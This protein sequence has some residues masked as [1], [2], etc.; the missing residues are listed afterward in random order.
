MARPNV[1]KGQHA[2]VGGGQRATRPGGVHLPYRFPGLGLPPPGSFDPGLEAQIRASQRGLIDL[3]E[4]T[5]RESKRTGQDVRQGQRKLG[6]EER[7]SV[8]DI[9]RERG[10]A[11]EDAA[12]AQGQLHT[13]F[14]RDIES[15]AIA[16]QRGEEDYQR[17]LVDMQHRYATTAAVQGERSLQQ[18]TAEGGTT[19]A[20]D[21]VRTANQAFDRGNV[22]TGHARSLFDLARSEDQ[23]RRDYGTQRGHIQTELERQLG[24]YDT[25]GTRL[26]QD[27]LTA[28][29]QLSLAALRAAQDRAT[30]LSHAKREQTFYQTDVTGQAYFQAHQNNPNILFPTPAAAGG[31][32]GAHPSAGGTFAP[33]VGHPVYHIG[34]GT[35]RAVSYPRRTARR[36][37]TRY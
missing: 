9:G 5:H 30:K 31:T 17:T 28:R 27:T 12:Y 11:T 18:G 37:Y 33:H 3:I 8:S 7:R 13:S 32:S 15:L 16:R 21:A 34:V 6:R 23:A 24:Q 35:G 20:T 22:D 14:A 29:H 1:R 4:Q 26:G 25:A 36:A 10:F 2:G 19:S